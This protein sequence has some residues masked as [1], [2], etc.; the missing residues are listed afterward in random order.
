LKSLTRKI[1]LI[2]GIS[3][4]V[5]F[6]ITN[7]LLYFNV[8]GQMVEAA[9][10]EAYGCAYI[11]TGMIDEKSVME[12]D[13]GDDEAKEFI[14]HELDW[15]VDHKQ[16]F[17]TQYILNLDG[18]IIASDSK[19]K[20]IGVSVGEN[21]PISEEIIKE[22]LETREPIYSE[23]YDF[24]G[25]GTLTGFAPIFE[26][27]D[28]TKE[29]V[30]ISA[31][32]FDSSIVFDRTFDVIKV[33]LIWSS[34]PLVVILIG[35]TFFFRNEIRPIELL[36]KKMEQVSEGDLT[37]EIDVESSDEVGLLA[38][39]LN[40]I[41]SRFRDVVGEINKNTLHLASTSEE[42]LASSQSIAEISSQNVVELS[43]ASDL[44][45]TQNSHI[46]EINEIIQSI[47]HNIQEIAEQLNIFAKVSDQTVSESV[48]GVEVMVEADTQMNN[49]DAK[50]NEL[51]N[52]MLS[53]GQKSKEID[54]IVDLINEISEQ[55]NI[56]SLNATIEAAR[57][58]ESGKGFAVVANEVRSL[59][60]D[61]KQSTSEIQALVEE[62]QDEVNE[63]LSGSEEG[64]REAQEGIKKISEAGRI[65]NDISEGVKG[66]NEDF[67]I[68][69]TSVEEISSEL[70]E[71]AATMSEV[72]GLIEDTTAKTQVVSEQI[73][74][75]DAS[76]EEMVE[77]TDNLTRLS[78]TLTEEVSYFNTDDNKN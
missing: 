62:I 2:A 26:D 46:N 77:V 10:V 55:T 14:R 76:F 52:V 59:A 15:T 42:L 5:S 58:G 63:A 43:E 24:N 33:S 4:T 25:Y 28:S 13:A 75:Q 30:G 64:H 44:S 70:E 65:F 22:L 73:N 9:G 34:V 47:T 56:L 19:L 54:D 57:A 38:N 32:D 20:D 68:S 16:I 12:A 49:I 6:I 18:E 27:K 40:E 8:K 74:E 69:T 37:V 45:Q 31:I 39:N 29:I 60:E 66:V 50:M 36:S 53:L 17:R 61:S 7:V 23:I 11:T 35:A 72:V 3:L 71:V 21:H 51:R 67:S 48:S 1:V 78:E 41:V